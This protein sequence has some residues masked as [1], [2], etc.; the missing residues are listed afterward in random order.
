M[1]WKSSSRPSFALEIELSF[2]FW[3]VK[4]RLARI[5]APRSS[6]H[7]LTSNIAFHRMATVTRFGAPSFIS[8]VNVEHCIAQNTTVTRF[9]TTSNQ[10]S[11]RSL[12][13][14]ISS[15]KLRQSHVLAPRSSFRSL[16]SNF[17]FHKMTTVTRFDAKIKLSLEFCFGN[18]AL[19]QILASQNSSRSNSG[20]PIFVSLVYV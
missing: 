20:V 17:A 3:R 1:L 19:V 5:L 7:T 12:T 9:D 13:S 18:Q 6:F 16:T 10:T 8:R 14:N 2:E 11:F 4:N 15:R